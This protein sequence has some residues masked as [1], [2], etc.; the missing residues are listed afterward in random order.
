MDATDSTESVPVVDYEAVD[1]PPLPGLPGHAPHDPPS[2]VLHALDRRAARL[3]QTWHTFP[4]IA[5]G[6]RHRGVPLCAAMEYHCLA[7]VMQ[8]L[9]ETELPD[10]VAAHARRPTQP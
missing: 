1:G 4:P 8:A 9:V 6:T 7:A 2:A 10:V 3:V 5:D